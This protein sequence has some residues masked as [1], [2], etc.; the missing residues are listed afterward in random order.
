MDPAIYGL[1]VFIWMNQ[2]ML[3]MFVFWIQEPMFV[4]FIFGSSCFWLKMVCLNMSYYGR[5]LYGC[6]LPLS[7]GI[8]C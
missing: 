2:H 7:T 8:G 6:F 3:K 1:N 5:K 4:M